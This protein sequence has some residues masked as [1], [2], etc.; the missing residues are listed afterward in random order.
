M[1]NVEARDAHCRKA[2]T[3]TTTITEVRGAWKKVE[4]EEKVRGVRGRI[5]RRRSASMTL[6]TTQAHLNTSSPCFSTQTN[7]LARHFSFRRDLL[8]Q[9]DED[10]QPDEEQLVLPFRLNLC[11]DSTRYTN[12]MSGDGS[13]FGRRKPHGQ[14]LPP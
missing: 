9:V 14:E 13:S 10:V 6:N 4:E 1:I 5:R 11:E 12:N 7:R 8:R 2:S 3:K